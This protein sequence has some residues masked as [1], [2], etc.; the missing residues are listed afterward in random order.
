MK[1]QKN[2][3]ENVRMTCVWLI[4]K[5]K[6]SIRYFFNLSYWKRKARKYEKKYFELYDLY[7]DKKEIENL[8]YKEK[9]LE[10]KTENDNYKKE[11]ALANEKITKLERKLKKYE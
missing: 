6:E 4:E 9:A 2:R 1:N 8:E 7:E 5:I 3:G 10:L 11:L